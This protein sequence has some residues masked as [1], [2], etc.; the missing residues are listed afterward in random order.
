MPRNFVLVVKGIIF[1]SITIEFS[2]MLTRF[3]LVWNSIA[4]VLFKFMCNLLD[5]NHYNTK[6]FH[7]N[8]FLYGFCIKVFMKNV[9]IVNIKKVLWLS[10]YSWEVVNV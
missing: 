9:S 3:C 8:S 2:S 4:T 7:I 5:L 10:T 1:S 6:H